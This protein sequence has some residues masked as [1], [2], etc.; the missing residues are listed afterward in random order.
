VLAELR[1]ENLLL[2]ERAEL[3][4]DPGLNVITGETGAGKTML[5]QALDLLLG[6]KPPGAI[7]RPGASEAYVE[8]V[9]TD[10]SALAGE[11]DL[12]E[13]GERV[14]LD[15]EDLVLARLMTA[16]GR[17]RAYVQGR[18]VSA[19][20]LRALGSRLTAMYG[21]HEHRKLML[22]SVQLDILDAFCG[23]AQ[24]DRREELRSVWTRARV[25]ERELEE[26]RERIG[27]RE[28]DLDLLD[29]EIAEIEE[30]SPTEQEEA[31]L[32]RERE[33]LAATEG[34][35]AASLAGLG[36]L[37]SDG[38]DG[39]QGALDLLAAAQAE[40][41]RQRGLD[42]ALDAIAERFERLV[43]DGQDLARGLRGY[44]HALDADP[45]RLEQIETRLDELSRLER[46]YGGT[47]AAVLD[48]ADRCRSRRALLA[49][50]EAD[51]ERIECELGEAVDLVRRLSRELASARAEAGP[52]LERAVRAEL[53]QLA[54]E[55]ARFEVA[56]SAVGERDGALAGLGPRGD[57]LAEF[58]I[59][60]N[61]GVAPG[62]LKEVASGGELSRVMLALLGVASGAGAAATVVFDEID[63][64]VGGKTARAVG[65]R[66]R[67][68]ARHRQVI[69]VTH[70][71]QVASLAE[72]HFRV[73]KNAAPRAGAVAR[74]EVERLDRGELVHELCR[75]LGADSAD[76]AA[77]QHAERLLQ[78][79]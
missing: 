65:E 43:L 20:D 61:K 64:G 53:R 42:P 75:M 17:T 29:F 28:R 38:R 21:Q 47:I 58:L 8:G 52:R 30:T 22:S 33:R 5:A 39:G 78:A 19:A 60:P 16:E 7:L 76:T 10:A 31:E 9:F 25:L 74:A 62:P 68:L 70:L 18:S 67:S 14:S 57:E 2:I 77:R 49:S 72:R 35:R 32:A 66:L 48:H 69:C 11:P 37:D 27:S 50:V 36:A 1:I 3:A 45:E 59:A 26:L 71:P 79:A 4:L 23:E 40:L 51:S 55:G 54:M 13:L 24:L 15:G 46:K 44:E 34:L 41:G 63:A 56:F 73:V 6:G 12:A